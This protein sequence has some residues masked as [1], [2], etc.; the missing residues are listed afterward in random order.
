MGK[1][2][3]GQISSYSSKKIIG[4]IGTSSELFNTPSIIQINKIKEEDNK[5]DNIVTEEFIIRYLNYLD[6]YIK[7]HYME[8]I[9]NK[10]LK[11]FHTDQIEIN[12]DTQVDLFNAL[13]IQEYGT[14]LLTLEQEKNIRSIY[15]T[16]FI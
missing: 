12:V 16:I 1:N 15:E 14:E 13:A 7:M 5:S 2:F 3:F 10:R 9:V 6:Q 4:I 8:N 11:Y